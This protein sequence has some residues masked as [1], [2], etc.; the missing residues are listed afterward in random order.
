MLC[1]DGVALAPHRPIDVKALDV[2]FYFCSWYKI[3]GPHIAQVYAHRR[4]QERQ[5]IS[6]NHSIPSPYACDAKLHPGMGCFELEQSLIAVVD[7][8]KSIGWS[9]IVHQEMVLQEALLSYLHS[10][11]D[12]FTVYGEPCSD[13]SR[14]ICL[15]SF[16]VNGRSSK[17]IENII[18]CHTKFRIAS[19]HAYSFR[20]LYDVL[21]LPGDGV[22]RVSFAH[23]NT[24]K[25]VKEF[26]N[27]LDRLLADELEDHILPCGLCGTGQ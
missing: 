10:R 22:I 20:Y 12:T 23:Y 27:M 16:R 11:M 21:G 26:T 17:E 13:P 19:G 1:V 25:E 8:I 4:V 5:M 2:D 6:I 9:S 14:R 3:F 18:Q 24:L 7:Y 15:V